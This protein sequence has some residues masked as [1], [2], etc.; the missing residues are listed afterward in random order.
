M[1][2]ANSS[3]CYIEYRPTSGLVADA[4]TSTGQ[5]DDNDETDDD[6]GCDGDDDDKMNS[7]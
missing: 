7:G 1:K 2:S 6:D 4:N 3:Y 5:T